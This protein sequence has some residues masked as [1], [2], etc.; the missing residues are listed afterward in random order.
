MAH[1]RVAS[2]ASN[3]LQRRTSHDELSHSE[4]TSDASALAW[5]WHEHAVASAN[6]LREAHARVAELERRVSEMEACEGSDV[7]RFVDE[8][9]IGNVGLLQDDGFAPCIVTLS[10]RAIYFD[11]VDNSG[12]QAARCVANRPLP[13]T[14]KPR[15]DA[16]LALFADGGESVAVLQFCS[17][18][19]AQAC[20]VLIAQRSTRQYSEGGGAAAR[21]STVECDHPPVRT[22]THSRVAVW[23]DDDLLRAVEQLT[24]ASQLG[25]PAAQPKKRAASRTPS[26]HRYDAPTQSSTRRSSSSSTQRH[27]AAETRKASGDTGSVQKAW[28]ETFSQRRP[29]PSRPGSLMGAATKSREHP[30]QRS[31]WQDSEAILKRYREAQRLKQPDVSGACGIRPVIN[32]AVHGPLA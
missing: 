7:L 5:K 13:I 15:D 32:S 14:T 9:R 12:G 21:S 17:P 20:A 11:L 25:V 2:L 19:N 22:T 28:D 1:S 31:A 4:A 29:S 10:H 24:S 6:A 3:V 30:T 8:L 16:T 18:A 27:E 26:P 23:S